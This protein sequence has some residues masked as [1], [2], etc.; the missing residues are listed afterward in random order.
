MPEEIVMAR[1]LSDN[2]GSDEENEL[3]I[4]LEGDGDWRVA[5]VPKG[6]FNVRGVRIST[7]G[8]A[9]AAVPGLGI[10]VARVFRAI[11]AAPEGNGVTH[12]R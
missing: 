1:F 9:S 4:F 3:T 7:S 6:A 11:A 10:S 8:G 5:T 2:R 12:V